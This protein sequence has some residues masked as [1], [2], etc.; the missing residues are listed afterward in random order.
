MVLA[1]TQELILD[2]RDRVQ[3]GPGDTFVQRGERRSGTRPQTTNDDP[4]P[5]A[6]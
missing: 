4:E 2:G 1:G 6:V 3:L 5:H